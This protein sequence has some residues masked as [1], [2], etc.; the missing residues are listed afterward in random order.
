MRFFKIFI[1]HPKPK[2][3]KKVTINIEKFLLFKK[4]Y[5]SKYTNYLQ[6]FQITSSG[7][8]AIIEIC[9]LVTG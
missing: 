4:I 2:R 6:A 9:S 3:R 5:F 8:G 1:H 7:V